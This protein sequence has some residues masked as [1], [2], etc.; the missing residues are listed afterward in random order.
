[1][2]YKSQMDKDGLKWQVLF[3][4][5]CRGVIIV[6]F[7]KKIKLFRCFI[8]VKWTKMVLFDWFYFQTC[9]KVFLNVIFRRKRKVFVVILFE[10][11]GLRWSQMTELVR[12]LGNNWFVEEKKNFVVFIQFLFILYL[13]NIFEKN[14]FFGFSYFSSVF[15]NLDFGW[16]WSTPLWMSF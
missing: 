9:L 8:R 10:T 1:L 15:T 6:D 5:L 2:F 4:N 3:R 13:I 11:H 7:I 12:N 14:F 16:G